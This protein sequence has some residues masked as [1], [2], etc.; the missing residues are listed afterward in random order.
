MPLGMARLLIYDILM[1]PVYQ[2]C[3]QLEHQEMKE[4][5]QSNELI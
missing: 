5:D 2:C 1:R 3:S 4:F